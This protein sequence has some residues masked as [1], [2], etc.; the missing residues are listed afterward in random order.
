M[1]Y[2]EWK[3]GG[4]TVGGMMTMPE[5]VP[6]EVPS[7]W[8]AYFAIADC[9]AT[10]ATATSLGATVM[11]PP[12]DIPAGRFSVLLDPAGAVFGIIAMQAT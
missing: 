6:A 8:L 2:T 7:H 4:K 12:M 9:D 3:L 5:Q 10:V 1:V 11:A